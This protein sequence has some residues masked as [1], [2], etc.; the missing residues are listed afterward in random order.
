MR[1]SA[2]DKFARDLLRKDGYEEFF[3]H[4]IGHGVGFAFHEMPMLS[5]TSDSIIELG[6]SLAIE[7]GIYIPEWG[8]IRV[9]DNI[10][11]LEEG[12]VE[13]LSEF[14]RGF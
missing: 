10:V 1:A 14:I 4:K 8:G 11:L 6:M 2:V 9:E 5:S 3:L 13:Y 7:P 12:R